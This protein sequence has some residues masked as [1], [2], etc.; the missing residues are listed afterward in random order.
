LITDANTIVVDFNN[1]VTLPEAN[2]KVTVY[3][4][5]NERAITAIKNGDKSKTSIETKK[6]FLA[7]AVEPKLTAA[8][9]YASSNIVNTDNA[10][11][12]AAA[13]LSY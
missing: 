4:T 5:F 10:N 1:V 3:A 13:K 12:K 7:V 8:A 6:E 9:W 11:A 2:Y